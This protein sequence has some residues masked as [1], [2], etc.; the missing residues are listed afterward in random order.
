MNELQAQVS[1]S[2]GSM[3][4]SWR[5]TRKVNQIDLSLISDVSQRHVS[6]LESG[7]ARPSQ[8][9]VVQLSEALRSPAARPKRPTPGGGFRAVISTSPA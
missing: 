9:M 1:K 2:F 7:R 5:A 3:L 4:K 6:F 8:P